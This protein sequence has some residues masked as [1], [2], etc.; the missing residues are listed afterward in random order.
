[1]TMTLP[2]FQY[3]APEG[4]DEALDLLRRHAPD[5]RLL[6]G[7]TDLLVA[8]RE[9][10]LRTGWLIDL[11]RIPGLTGISVKPSGELRIGALTPVRDVERSPLVREGWLVL[12][13]A[14]GMLASIQVRNKATIGGNLCNASPAAD[15]APPLLVLDARAIAAGPDGERAFPIGELFAGPGRTTLSG[16]ILV[17]IAVPPMPA[18]A[19]ASYQKHGP[20]GA[21]DIAIAGVAVLGVPAS[22]ATGTAGGGAAHWAEVRIALGAVAATPV[23]A[24][25]AEAFLRGA[26]MD[27][28]TIRE[29][30]QLAAE[31]ATPISDVR[32]SAAYR[33]A[34]I[35]ALTRRALEEVAS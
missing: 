22:E 20:R 27:G 33:T 18:G 29:A 28:A 8:M 17:G 25:E 24:P 34:M 5:A 21:M 4:L 30:A 35:A 26:P 2:P 1:M 3:A 23:R 9:R 10:G 32:G 16:E 31:R 15:L 11:K 6:A 12:S 13:A 7:G 19:R 14:A